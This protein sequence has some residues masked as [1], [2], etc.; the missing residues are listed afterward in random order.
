MTRLFLHRWLFALFL[1]ATNP[2]ITSAN[3]QLSAKNLLAAPSGG[4]VVQTDQVR[5]ELL[6]H[7]PEGV[8][9]GKPVWL[10]LQLVHQPHWHT[11]WKNPGDSGLP[12]TLNWTLPAGVQAGDIV[13]PT[14]QRITVGTL[15]NFGFENTLLLPVP[16]TIGRDFAPTATGDLEVQLHATWLV[17]HKECIPQEGTFVLKVPAQGSTA[18]NGAAFDAARAA[19]PVTHRGT[20]QMELQNN[21]ALL[22]VR[23]LPAAWQ[24]RTLQVFPEPMNVVDVPATAAQ[25]WKTE[26]DNSATWSMRLPLSALRETSPTTLAVVL[27]LDSSSLRAEATVQGTWPAVQPITALPPTPASAPMPMAQPSPQSPSTGWLVALLAAVLGGLI[28]NLMPCVLPVLAIKV[29]G[30]AEHAQHSRA[31]QRLQGLAYTLGVVLSFVALGALMLVL[32]ARG[33]QLGWGFHLQS[34]AVVAALA[35][36]FTL[37]ALNLAGLLEVGNLLPQRLATLQARHPVGDAFLSGVLAVAI[38]APCTA[39]FMGASLGYA[40]TQPTAQAL[41]IFVAL[42]LG[43]ALPFLLV[44]WIPRAAHWLPR[45]G[46]WMQRLRQ[47]MAFPMLATV[48]WLVWVL[49]HLSGVDGAGA[50]LALLLGLALLVWCVGVAQRHKAVVAAVCVAAFGLLFYN[51]APL[52]LQTTAPSTSNA[53]STWQAWAPGKVEAELGAGRSVFVDFTAA[54]C[55]TC[56]YN[57]KTTLSNPEVLADVA[58]KQVTLLRADWTRRDPAITQ[59]LEQLGRSGVPVYVLYAPGKAPVVLS[60]IL[61]VGD[62]RTAL[63]TL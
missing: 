33:E 12:T 52:V 35:A 24:G 18:W 4:A 31:S 10:G 11:Y 20:A 9:M 56:Q 7:V 5:A 16:L 46:A 22:Q 47:F 55:I 49:G 51:A 59:A 39:P 43:L 27:A 57:K 50:L 2:F 41:G 42:G 17:C 53:D 1:I 44:S 13:W 15:A 3:A 29:L 48:V 32:R 30:M 61:T 25:S 34:P 58:T 54:W 37:L 23:G 14:P 63:V 38:A 62:V 26:G 6:A 45:P 19:A 21:S 36:L 60:E 40:I 28:L 8:G